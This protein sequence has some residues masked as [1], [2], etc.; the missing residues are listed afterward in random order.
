[1]HLRGV[2][3][4]CDVAQRR[5]FSKG[6]AAQ[7]LS[8][9]AA[10]QAVQTL[11]D[12]LG[13]TLIDRSQR[14]LELTPAGQVYF[15]GCR[16]LLERFRALEDQV[17]RMQNMVVGTVRVAAIYSVGLMQM[18][19]YI[20]QFEERYPDAHLRLEYVHPDEVYARLAN[21]GADLGLVSFPR[22]GGDF[23]ALEWQNQPIVLVV[24]PR[25]RLAGASSVSLAELQDEDYVGF[26]EDLSI[27]KEVDRWLRRA[28][29]AVTIVR[30]FDN[31]E[32]IKS[33]IEIGSGIALLPEPTVWQETSA[34]TLKAIPLRDAQLF[35]PVG[36]VHRRH[37][38]LTTP[39]LKWI[40]LLQNGPSSLPPA[41]GGTTSGVAAESPLTEPAKVPVDVQAADKRTSR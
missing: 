11:E 41:P 38:Q 32:S 21:D 1:M 19:T 25:H 13:T 27:R 4:F 35:R 39:A 22:H 29:V 28:K 5:S 24:P 7:N 30:E 16:E 10:S 26:T 12:R 17:R 6:A 15:D 23:V 20:H 3:I 14:P 34:G 36:I 18:E 9:S 2:E 40:D 8:Q 37:K 31:I 33:A